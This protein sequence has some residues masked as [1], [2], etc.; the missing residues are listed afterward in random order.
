MAFLI[1]RW[2]PTPKATN[3]VKAIVWC[4]DCNLRIGIRGH[5]IS[6]T[7]ELSPSLVCPHEGCNFHEY[8]QLRNYTPPE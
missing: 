6:E 5:E 1:E 2:V 3:G 8:V 7:G 4:P